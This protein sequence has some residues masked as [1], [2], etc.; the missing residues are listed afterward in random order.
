MKEAKESLG[1]EEETR[2]ALEQRSKK[3]ECE[4][5]TLKREI[6]DLELS[7]Q[8]VNAD[9]NSGLIIEIFSTLKICE[10][11]NKNILM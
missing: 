8:K 4:N 9:T 3:I 2:R 10:K 5:Q 6:Q 7:V 1:K 11:I